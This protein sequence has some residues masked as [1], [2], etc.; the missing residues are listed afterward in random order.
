MLSRQ[1]YLLWRAVELR[2]EINSASQAQIV[3]LG[4]KEM[5]LSLERVCDPTA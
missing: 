3:L 5:Q 2:K 1:G 4:S